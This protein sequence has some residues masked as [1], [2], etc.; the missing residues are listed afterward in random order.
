MSSF[1]D[2]NKEKQVLI[3]TIICTHRFILLIVILTVLAKVFVGLE[4]EE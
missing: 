1:E 2:L 4:L 3:L